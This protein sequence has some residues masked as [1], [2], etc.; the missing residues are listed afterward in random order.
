MTKREYR[1][2]EET[3][4]VER[5]IEKSSMPQTNEKTE[6]IGVVGTGGKE[7]RWK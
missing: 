7:W 3:T 2:N 1:W 5:D 6:L 4:E